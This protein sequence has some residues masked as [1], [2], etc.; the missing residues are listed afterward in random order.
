MYLAWT[1]RLRVY[2]VFPASYL[3][4]IHLI[5]HILCT[6]RPHAAETRCVHHTEKHSTLHGNSCVGFNGLSVDWKI[7]ILNKNRIAV[8]LARNL[9]G[10]IFEQ[11]NFCFS[12]FP[13]YL[14]LTFP[15]KVWSGLLLVPNFQ[16][17]YFA[18]SLRGKNHMNFFSVFYILPV[19]RK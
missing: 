5:R 4:K 14:L 8:F 11:S 2:S 18:N 7:S 19:I 10:D 9:M 1:V 15:F 12:L 17:I 6:A 13:L 3:T 16:L